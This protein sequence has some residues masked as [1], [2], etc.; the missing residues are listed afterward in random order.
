M[1]DLRETII[2][3]Y[4]AAEE[5]GDVERVV[6][7]CN[8]IVVICNAAF[9]PAHGKQG[10]RDYVTNFRDRTEKR[11]LK[12]KSIALSDDVGYAWWE[13]NLTFRAGVSFG[14]VKTQHPFDLSLQGICR[15]KFDEAN[16]LTE[17][18][19]FHETTTG[20]QLAQAAAGPA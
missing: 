5:I 4:F 18:D 14:P 16:R 7:M 6:S 8:D 15:F 1:N 11:E 10:C 2:M 17:P 20:F 9:P 19:V 3:D 12:V 13:A